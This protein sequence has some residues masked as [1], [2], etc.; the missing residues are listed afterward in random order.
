MIKKF[1]AVYYSNY[2]FILADKDAYLSSFSSCLKNL[3]SQKEKCSLNCEL[4]SIHFMR[5]RYFICKCSDSCNL[6]L[7]TTKKEFDKNLTPSLL[8][9]D[10]FF[11]FFFYLT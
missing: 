8:Q 7:M 9:V 10:F 1:Y 6:K 4:T 3:H 11:F 2:F 5:Q